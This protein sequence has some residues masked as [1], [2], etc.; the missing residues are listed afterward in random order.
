ARGGRR[1]GLARV[2]TQH[3]EPNGPARLLCAR[4]ERPCGSAADK[5]D[6]R[7][8]FHSI[9]SSASAMSVGGTSRPSALAVLALI[10]SSKRVGCSTG[11]SDG[12]DPL[13]ILSTKAAARRQPSDRL[14]P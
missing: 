12:R 13:R 11:K 6:E 14:A 5:R 9:T 4:R 7:A 3:S 1:L 8:A 10:I 2:R